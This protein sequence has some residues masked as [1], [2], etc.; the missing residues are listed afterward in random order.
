MYYREN[1]EAAKQKLA[2]DIEIIQK[3]IELIPQILKAFEPLDGKI[4]NKKFAEALKTVN[5]YLRN[6]IDINGIVE[7]SWC[8]YEYTHSY[9]TELYLFT[10]DNTNEKEFILTETGKY[11][12]DFSVFKEKS[13]KEMA[14]L[15]AM[16]E[17]YRAQIN[18]AEETS[19]KYEQ[20]SNE[21]DTFN[22]I[23][24]YPLFE[25]LEI[26]YIKNYD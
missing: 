3:G 20:L 6:N 10:I 11:R 12:F 16:Q 4:Y 19:K 13:E 18:K 5:P 1:I 23:R 14:R 8:V 17:K 26:P 7:I 25:Y 22:H 21:I 15:T 9:N 24:E 2:K